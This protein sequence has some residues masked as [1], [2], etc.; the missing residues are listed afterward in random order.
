MSQQKAAA[1]ENID[2][3]SETSRPPV[4]ELSYEQA[5]QELIQ[6]VA[7][8]E[9]GSANLEETIALWERGEQLAARCQAWLDGARQRLQAAQEE[10]EQ[11]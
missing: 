1:Q 11:R 8:M 6:V 5:R 10:Q 2:F 4:A 7:D 3:K 9:S